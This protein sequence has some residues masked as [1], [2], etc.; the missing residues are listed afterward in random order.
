[1]YNVTNSIWYY[2]C[3]KQNYFAHVS[4]INEQHRK[5]ALTTSRISNHNDDGGATQ[6]I[7][8]W[9][10][11]LKNK[12][13]LYQSECSIFNEYNILLIIVTLTYQI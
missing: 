13:V 2:F 7:R 5:L 3:Y 11:E 4:F 1:M 12:I 10:Y 9:Y 8:S 6:N